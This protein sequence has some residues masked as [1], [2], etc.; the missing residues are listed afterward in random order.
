MKECQDAFGR[1]MYDYFKSKSGLEI[2]ERDDG[3]IAFSGGPAAYFHEY[4]RWPAYQRQAMRYARGRVLDIGCGAG[5]H[6]LHLQ[7][8]G[9]DV[10]GIDTSPL[11][12]KVSRLRGLRKAKTMSISQVNSKLGTFDT[13]LM[14]GNNFGLFG[15]FAGARRL[16]KRFH[17]MSTDG[18]RIIAESL[19]PYKTSDPY[20]LAY[21]KRNRRRGRMSGQLRIRVRYKS[22]AT[23]WF[24]YLLASPGEVEK[25]L[26]GTGWRLARILQGKDARYVAVIVKKK[27]ES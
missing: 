7:K 12:I 27:D 4:K 10:L 5:R 22:I 14:L 26:K 13:F 25:I 19:D 16:L 2:V 20:H 23:P 17:A 18:A 1:G 8:K 15:S 21:E 9:L 11:A 3:Y 24:A 6:S